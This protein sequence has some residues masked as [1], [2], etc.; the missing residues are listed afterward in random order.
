MNIKII[1]TLLLRGMNVCSSQN[2]IKQSFICLSVCLSNSEAY[3]SSCIIIHLHRKYFGRTETPVCLSVHW[4]KAQETQIQTL[5]LSHAIRQGTIE[6]VG[7]RLSV[8]PIVLPSISLSVHPDRFQPL[9]P[10]AL[11]LL[12]TITKYRGFSH[13]RI[14]RAVYL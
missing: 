4:T 2:R 14:T 10:Q 12:Y 6:M 7:V 5:L 1:I 8:L 13:H 9:S 11:I 3:R